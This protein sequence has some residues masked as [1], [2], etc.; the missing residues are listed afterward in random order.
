MLVLLETGAD[1]KREEDAAV[2]FDSAHLS[3][4]TGH[5]VASILSKK[6][7]AVIMCPR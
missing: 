6:T 3:Q 4:E 7:P 2:M 5:L 1:F